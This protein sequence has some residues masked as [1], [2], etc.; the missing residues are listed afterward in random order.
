MFIVQIYESSRISRLYNLHPGIGTH[1][2]TVSSPLGIIQYVLFSF[3]N[4]DEHD[5]MHG[6]SLGDFL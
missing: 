5:F 1:S 6:E 3:T 4:E 2:F